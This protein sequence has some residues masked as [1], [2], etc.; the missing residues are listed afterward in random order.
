MA[1][2]FS[3]APVCDPVMLCFFARTHGLTPSEEQVL[4]ILCQGYSAPQ[5]ARQLN[6][7]VSTVRSHVRS[8]CAKTQS[9]GVRALLARW[10]CCRPLARR[11]CRRR[12]TRNPARARRY[13]VMLEFSQRG[14]RPW[15][16][17]RPALEQDRLIA[18]LDPSIGRLA[19]R[20]IVR[21][22]RKNTIILNEG[23]PAIRCSSCCKGR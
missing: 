11:T 5:V 7:A 9:N 13:R 2:I 6:V 10:P 21:S 22:Y 14:R 19:A 23:E 4:A 18:Q 1:L 3:R 16:M 17:S 15:N 20:G 12:C 8:M